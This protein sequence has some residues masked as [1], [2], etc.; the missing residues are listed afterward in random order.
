MRTLDEVLDSDRNVEAP[1]FASRRLL[2][3][4]DGI[5]FLLSDAIAHEGSINGPWWHKNHVET[6]Y[7]V[8]GEGELEVLEACEPGIYQIKPG[9]LYAPDKHA[10]HILQDPVEID[11]CVQAAP[12]WPGSTR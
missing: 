10:R 5:E 6:C 7:C 9:T 11:L 12:H 1:T 8:E 3:K 2:L 4:K